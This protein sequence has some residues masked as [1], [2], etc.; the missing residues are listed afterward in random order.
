MASTRNHTRVTYYATLKEKRQLMI[1]LLLTLLSHLY[2]LSV[3]SLK[4]LP[5]SPHSSIIP[6]P[7]CPR[8]PNTTAETIAF[9]GKKSTASAMAKRKCPLLPRPPRRRCAASSTQFRRRSGR[10]SGESS[11]PRR[12]VSRSEPASREASLSSRSWR[13]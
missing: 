10:S 13:D 7:P 5:P 6:P 3:H 8:P 2:S 9:P 1:L 11:S 12:R 4:L